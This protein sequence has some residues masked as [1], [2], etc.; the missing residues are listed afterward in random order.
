LTRAQRIK[1]GTIAGAAAPV[2]GMLGRTW[3]WIEDG[4][5][6]LQ[7]LE[8]R[9]TPPI[10]ALWHGR[11]LPATIYFRDRGIVAMTSRNFDGE[12]IARLMRRFGYAQAR[13]S[14]SRGGS[15]ALIQMKQAL[16]AG[17]TVAFT[18]DGPRGPAQRGWLRSRAGPSCH[19][20]SR[21]HATGRRA[22][23]TPRRCQNRAPR[24]RSPSGRRCMQRPI[25]THRGSRPRVRSSNG[26][27]TTSSNAQCRFC[28]PR[29][30]Q[31]KVSIYPMK[32]L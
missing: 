6:H 21:P 22:A 30:D 24:S 20:T 13:G 25:S 17:S 32:E 4:A 16:E 14:S 9:R 1:A 3:R 7:A 11:I 10:L 12:W 18:V 15:R 29:V 19:F 2:V 8:A 26:F 23:G 31:S 27:C 5:E 28:T